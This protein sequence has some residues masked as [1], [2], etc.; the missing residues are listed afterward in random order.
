[1]GT[2]EENMASVAWYFT[3]PLHR[4]QGIGTA[5]WEAFL[6]SL[7]PEINLTLNS[8][9]N[10]ISKYKK[11]N[12]AVAGPRYMS[13]VKLL[14]QKVPI[15]HLPKNVHIEDIGQVPMEKIH[16]YDRTMYP[17]SRKIFME[18]HLK[19][20]K[21]GVVAVN[22]DKDVTG[23]GA[24]LKTSSGVYFMSPLYAD[25]DVIAHA[26]LTR[27]LATIPVNSHMWCMTPKDNPTAIHLFDTPG[28]VT[29]KSGFQERGQMLFTK[30]PYAF[31]VSK[32]YAIPAI[33]TPGF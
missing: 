14:K 3:D 10:M 25:D 21:K 27:L 26:L 17:Q 9:S 24:I 30:K 31:P 16:E 7:P 6:Q 29:V 4:G 33:Y 22:A 12:I 1:M 18:T 8:F 13:D 5:V 28:M 20:V 15:S 11:Y 32:I 23:F 2:L 19:R